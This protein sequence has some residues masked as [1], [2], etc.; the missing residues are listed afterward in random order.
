M[1][2][3][4]RDILEGSASVLALCTNINWGEHP[5]GVSLPGIVLNVIDDAEQHHLDSDEGPDGLS[6]GRVQVDCYATT[7]SLAKRMERA[8]RAELDGYK[9]GSFSGIFLVA[10]RDNRDGGAGEFE[11][12]YRMSMD[13]TTNWRP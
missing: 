3:A 4:F 11:R 2:E 6:R 12:P 9:G 8:V 13:F 10:T 7:Y 5:Q 1:E